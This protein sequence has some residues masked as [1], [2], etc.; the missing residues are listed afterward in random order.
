LA[1]AGSSF[2]LKQPEEWVIKFVATA[3]D[4]KKQSLF[5]QAAEV[6]SFVLIAHYALD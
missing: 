4:A 2:L 6:F 1:R 3:T 5:G